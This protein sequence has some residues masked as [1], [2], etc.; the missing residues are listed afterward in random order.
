MSGYSHLL[1]TSPWRLTLGTPQSYES[2]PDDLLDCLGTFR[3]EHRPL[4]WQ[5]MGSIAELGQRGKSRSPVNL[6]DILVDRL[7]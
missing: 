4:L 6:S 1:L 7:D 5:I 2:L 3:T